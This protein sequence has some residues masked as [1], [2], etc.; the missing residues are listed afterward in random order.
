VGQSVIQGARIAG[1]AVVIAID[2]EAS[3]RESAMLAGATH[4]LDPAT[5]SVLEAVRGLTDGR[6][7]D[8]SFEAVG[9]TDL[10]TQAIDIARAAGTVTIVGMPAKDTTITLPAVPTVFSGKRISGS[11]VGGAQ[12][13][14][15][16][17]KFVRLV[18]SGRLEVGSMISHTI[19][20][21][22]VND[23][24]GRMRSAEGLRTVI[25]HGGG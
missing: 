7:V 16:L 24:I 10:I 11:V 19:G 22:E 8:F 23:G 15:D 1:A 18:E 4:T 14:R 12:I 21:D 3:R 5:G 20:L 17:P 6:G 9:H 25:L 13:L 2:P